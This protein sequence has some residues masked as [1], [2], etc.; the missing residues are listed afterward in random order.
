MKKYTLR[1]ILALTAALLLVACG[2]SEEEK[3]KAA[4]Q[5]AQAARIAAE[6]AA[7]KLPTDATDKTS[8]QKYLVAQVTRF[9]RENPTLVKTNHP[10]MY[11]VPTGDGA[12][13][14]NDRNNQLDNVKTTV[15]RGVLPG[16]LMAFGG[17]DSKFTADLMVEAFKEAQDNALKGVIV[18]FVGAQGDSDRVKEAVAKSGADFRFVELR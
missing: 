15:G 16:N 3:Q 18:L 5:A 13:Q 1:V 17:P 6:Q 7:L 8:W 14:Q 2:P 11:Y 12:D 9:M 4:D 10:Y